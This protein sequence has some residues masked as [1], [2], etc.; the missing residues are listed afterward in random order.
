IE[1]A[2]A[3][4]DTVMLVGDAK[5][6]IYR[7]R[8]GNPE[9]M[10]GLI[11]RKDELN[12]NVENLPRNWRS[13]ENII[14]FNNEFYTKIG[15]SLPVDTYREL[16]VSGNNQLTNHKKGGFVQ[17]NFISDSKEETETYKE[18]TLAQL[19]KNIESIRE[20]G[21]QYAEI[22]ILFR[23]NSHGE[24][25][26]EYLAEKNIPILS[27]E[28]L[29]VGNSPEIQAIELFFKTISNPEDKVSKAEFLLK[30]FEI[31]ILTTADITAEIKSV[32]NSGIPQLVQYL[33]NYEID[34]EFI[35]QPSVSLY[36][37]TEKTIEAFGFAQKNSAYIQFFLD[38]I[39][40]YSSQHEYSL[41]RFL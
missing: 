1:N 14:E 37:F 30:L 23:R 36:D 15:E 9:Q 16:Y 3:G 41:P 32:L 4:S 40:E 21:F 5:Q 39:L 6:S 20:Q 2:R 19:L 26:A 38:Y 12:I 22:A 13:F 24:L 7:F 11:E 8:G 34:L 31:G 25:I 33:K 10:L 35:H 28:S 29:L 17:L 18:N 27:A